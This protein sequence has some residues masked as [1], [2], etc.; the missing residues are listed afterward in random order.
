MH[1]EFG[2]IFF[3]IY[4][5]LNV[6]RIDILLIFDLSKVK[7][8]YSQGRERVDSKVLFIFFTRKFLSKKKP[9]RFEVV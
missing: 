9:P 1:P 2:C 7:V 3:L 6:F 8:R 5:Y 4:F